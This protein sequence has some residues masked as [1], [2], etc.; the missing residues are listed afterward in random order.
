VAGGVAF[1]PHVESWAVFL[2]R[3]EEVISTQS[4]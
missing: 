2:P 1:G 4:P 3:G